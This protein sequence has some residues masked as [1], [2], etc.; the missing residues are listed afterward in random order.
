MELWKE[1]G[2]NANM[3][4]QSRLLSKWALQNDE[5]LLQNLYLKNQYFIMQIDLKPGFN[6]SQYV[7][8]PVVFGV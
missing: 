7:S 2:K 3:S 4:R 5:V 6:N 1:A 8:A